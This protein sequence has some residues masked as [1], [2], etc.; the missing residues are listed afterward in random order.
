[1]A[2]DSELDPCPA[3]GAEGAES[4]GKGR[5]IRRLSHP[6]YYFLRIYN[7]SGKGA[8]TRPNQALT[9]DSRCFIFSPSAAPTYAPG[10][11]IPSFPEFHRFHLGLDGPRP[12]I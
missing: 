7:P 11:I 8:E 12:G 10:F 6:D 4:G 1:M 5:E 3:W 2:G 9:A